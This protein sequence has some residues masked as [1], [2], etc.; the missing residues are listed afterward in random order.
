MRLPSLRLPDLR[1]SGPS[2]RRIRLG[3]LEI[4]FIVG[5]LVL[6]SLVIGAYLIEQRGTTARAADARVINVAGRQ[7]MLTQRIAMLT[8]RLTGPLSAAQRRADRA[9]LSS[10]AAALL[11]D[12]ELL[13]KS[14]ETLGAD[15]APATVREVR[16]N[17]M[18]D[19]R[20][21]RFGANAARLAKRT[22]P[23]NIAD[24]TV[25][26]VLKSAR[27]GLPRDLDEIAKH[28]ET[29]SV[30]S[31]ERTNWVM[32]VGTG[33]IIA[34]LIILGV[35]IFWP[36]ARRMRREVSTVELL[37]EVAVAANSANTI[38]DA[39]LRCLVL[40]CEHLEWPVG[41]VFQPDE[42]DGS[43]RSAGIWHVTDQHRYRTFMEATK[44]V[45][46]QRGV[47]L[48]GRVVVTG[49]PAWINDVRADDGFTRTAQAT[50]AGLVGGVAFPIKV[51]DRIVGVIEGF[52]STRISQSRRVLR[53]LNQLGV[54]LAR[55][56]ERDLHQR[57]LAHRAMHDELTG[58][59]NR[60]LLLERAAEAQ[61][62]ARLSGQPLALLL[63]DLD[64][65]KLTNDALGHESGDRML[66]AVGE[67]LATG[68]RPTD[69]VS[70]F[71]GDE[72]AILCEGLE[73][74][75]EAETLARRIHFLLQ[76]QVTVD[77]RWMSVSASVGI[78]IGR[79]REAAED[80]LRDADTA[81]YAAKRRGRGRQARFDVAMREEIS[82]R[83]RLADELV[84]AVSREEM[85]LFLQP[86]IDLS[87]NR[88]KGFEALVR[89][90]HPVRGLVPPIAFIPLAEDSG[91]IGEL[92]A[93]VLRESMRWAAEIH[94]AVT[95]SVN[96]S[97]RQLEDPGIVD[98]VQSALTEHDVPAHRLTLEITESVLLDGDED[99]IARLEELRTLG[100]KLSLD[101]FGTG[102]SSLSYLQDLP[103]DI[104]KLDRSFASR[105]IG[106]DDPHASAIIRTV[107]S[108]AKGLELDFV[109][110]GV[111]TEEQL[112]RLKMLGCP[113]GQG[114]LFSKPLPAAEAIAFASAGK[115]PVE[116]ADPQKADPAAEG[117]QAA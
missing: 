42:K 39:Y 25:Q 13:T 114:Y 21:Q 56:I 12:H 76:Q 66:T 6:G 49:E 2:D 96:L 116:T 40:V 75:E 54:Q 105:L 55:V 95:V 110:E 41:H 31:S 24:P 29:Q 61:N 81:M 90:Q 108:L 38:E 30:E 20:I 65:F 45:H 70:R 10:A 4:S 109:V 57:D 112:A 3:T 67:R 64:N 52:S 43:L 46:L 26:S 93:W 74:E 101:D 35:L 27:R 94:P 11:A 19:Q 106:K 62:R 82:E 80:L 79:G 73:N 17:R 86:I 59:P 44:R 50:E 78:A 104:L 72:F 107:A 60:A 23:L 14:P 63:L 117:Q 15:Q 99:Q 22:A 91:L 115:D 97:T 58:L 1:R 88:L 71:G 102:Y 32:F 84:G 51:G 77:D 83:L 9:E 85:R 18:V 92:G 111:E 37:E 69:L 28:Y 87:T 103:L 98:T 68:M 33:T 5:M 16:A 47:G 53:I 7:T 100:A 34:G 113:L 89:W 48:A 36:M 8:T